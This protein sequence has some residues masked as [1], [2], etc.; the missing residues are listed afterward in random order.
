M[1]SVTTYTNVEEKDDLMR[2]ASFTL[3]I[4]IAMGML[5]CATVIYFGVRKI[6]EG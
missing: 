3:I 6:I 2:K 5:I 4:G 1:D